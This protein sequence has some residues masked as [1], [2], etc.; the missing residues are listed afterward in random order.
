[1][2]TV[3]GWLVFSVGLLGG[4]GRVSASNQVWCSSPEINFYGACA[5][6]VTLYNVMIAGGTTVAIIGVV[7][8]VK[9]HS[10]SWYKHGM[11]TRDE[12]E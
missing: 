2:L 10:S 7:I 3:A 12:L 6:G 1:M 5:C 4:V 9:Q 11:Y 8:L